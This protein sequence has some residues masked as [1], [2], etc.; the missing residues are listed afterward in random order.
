MMM[1]YKLFKSGDYVDMSA[2]IVVKRLSSDDD[3]DIGMALGEV[4]EM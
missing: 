3:L 4:D 1:D 2:G